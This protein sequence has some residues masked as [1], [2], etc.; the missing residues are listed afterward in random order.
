MASSTAPPASALLALLKEE[1]FDLED[2]SKENENGQTPLTYFSRM[3]NVAMCRY[4]I[5][6]GADC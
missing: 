6:R 4:L 1:G 2:V 3:G 5:A